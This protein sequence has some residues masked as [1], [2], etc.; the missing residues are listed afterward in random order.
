AAQQTC[1]ALRSVVDEVVC[2]YTPEP[3][4]AVGLWYD[5]FTQTTDAEVRA[6]LDAARHGNLGSA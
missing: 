1:H 2:G 5:D 6:L 3:F 4:R